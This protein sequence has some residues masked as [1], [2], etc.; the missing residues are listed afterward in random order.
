M[1]IYDF[2]CDRCGHVFSVL[3]SLQERD[4]V[5]CP[6]CQSKEV[7]QIIS[8]C[9]VRSGGGCSSSGGFDSGSWRGG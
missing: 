5:A 4:K 2:K 1:P 9:S 6:Q 8:A 7:R 3:T